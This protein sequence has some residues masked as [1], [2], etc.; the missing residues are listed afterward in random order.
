[1]GATGGVAE[2]CQ[3]FED[4]VEFEEE[5]V[6]CIVVHLSTAPTTLFDV[7]PAIKDSWLYLVVALSLLSLT[8]YKFAIL[9]TKNG[10][11]KDLDD[12]LK[13]NQ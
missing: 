12:F 3:A 2:I 1:M 7:F 5:R 4:L 10:A 11:L 13:M 9:L 6:R 8:I